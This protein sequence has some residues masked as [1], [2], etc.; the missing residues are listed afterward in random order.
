V[1]GG[2]G[3]EAGKLEA[4]AATHKQNQAALVKAGFNNTF[5]ASISTHTHVARPSTDEEKI[6]E[7]IQ[8]GTINSKNLWVVCGATVFNSEVVMKARRQFWQKPIRTQPHRRMQ[9]LL[10][11][12]RLRWPRRLRRSGA[13]TRAT[14]PC[15]GPTWRRR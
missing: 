12:R 5:A 11:S 7:L 14:A 13:A 10:N 6:A 3:P 15:P 1:A 4:L 9:P 8:L 2:Q